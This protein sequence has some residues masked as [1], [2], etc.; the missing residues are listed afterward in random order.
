MPF[1]KT[2]L[3]AYQNLPAWQSFR[4]FS[5]SKWGRDISKITNLGRHLVPFQYAE[6]TSWFQ[7]K[8]RAGYDSSSQSTPWQAS[9]FS[10]EMKTS[11]HIH[12]CGTC[13]W[14]WQSLS[15]ELLDF[16]LGGKTTLPL[17]SALVIT[18][19]VVLSFNSSYY[20]CSSKVIGRKQ[21]EWTGFHGPYCYEYY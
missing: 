14:F 13:T 7:N 2:D 8:F 16:R 15:C 18:T 19:M 12:D 4:F 3:D 1:I 21:T 17:Q 10:R 20:T 11:R 5:V 6:P 9:T